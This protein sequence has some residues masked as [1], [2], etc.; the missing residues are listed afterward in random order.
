MSVK[1][2]AP[3]FNTGGLFGSKAFELGKKVAGA[4]S[5]N[6]LAIAG[7]VLPGDSAAGKAL[8]IYSAA[9]GLAGGKPQD[10]APPGN[11]YDTALGNYS[12]AFTPDEQMQAL[13]QRIF[14]GRY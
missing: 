7:A 13:Q 6:P 2:A 4:A 1:V 8:N 11:T 10:A 9:N 14:S 12:K 3:E 5:G